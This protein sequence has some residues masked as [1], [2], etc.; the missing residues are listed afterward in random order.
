MFFSAGVF[1]LAYK[2]FGLIAN[3]AEDVR[4]PK[5]TLSKTLYLS[6]AVVIIIYVD[7]SLTIIGNLAIP[8]I[9]KAK[10]YALAEAAKPFLGLIGFKI[11][12]IAAFFPFFRNK[13]NF[14]W[15]DKY[16]LFNG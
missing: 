5:R 1:F 12:A 13:C 11:M 10:D 9:I 3:A 4:D 2:G 8:E 7:V 6:I 15:W 16:K 14:I